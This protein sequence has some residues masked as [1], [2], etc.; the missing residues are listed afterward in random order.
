MSI[1]SY[2]ALVAGVIRLVAR[3][4]RPGIFSSHG[5]H[6]WAAWLTH[7]LMSDARTGLFAFYASVLTP[8]WLR[9]LG[10]R[11][12]RGVEASTIVAAPSLLH[13]GNG[14][15]LA[16]DVLLAPFEL[17]GSKLAL[18]VSSVGQRAFV[19][20]SG[21]VGPDHS[22]PDESLIGVLGSSPV[23][24]QK[25]PGSSWLGRPIISIPRRIDEL[26][27]ERL[28]F[29]PPL[30][31]KIA[32]GAV[33]SMRVV[34]LVISALFIELLLAAMIAVLDDWGLTIAIIAG[35]VLL[36]TAGVASCLL[37]TAAKWTLIPN[38][39]AGHQHP[40]WSSFVWRNE[41]ALTFVES[42]ALPWMLRLLY[43]TPLL[44]VWLRTM[45]T[46]VGRGV[47]CETHR[48][49]WRVSD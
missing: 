17:R 35:G 26:P 47:W 22:T 24:S 33:E 29:D 39:A 49:P 38:I 41:L 28:S 31:L 25:P 32:R 2:A 4:M 36:F 46:E 10:A 43:G 34:P 14:S 13:A 5:A 8:T 12:G 42:L 45:G 3:Y 1:V 18:G 44:N 21:I 23:P 20:N 6:A 15:F 48:G 7:R 27:D 9:I 30:R 16:D 19:G 40:L 37:A 11:I